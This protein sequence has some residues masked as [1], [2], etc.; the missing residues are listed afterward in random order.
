MPLPLSLARFASRDH[1]LTFVTDDGT[2]PTTPTAISAMPA[3]CTQVAGTESSL[4]IALFKYNKIAAYPP[5][6]MACPTRDTHSCVILR[7]QRRSR[8]CHASFRPCYSYL[9]RSRKKSRIDARRNPGLRSRSVQWSCTEDPPGTSRQAGAQNDDRPMTLR[10]LAD[11]SA[12]SQYPRMRVDFPAPRGLPLQCLRRPVCRA[13]Q[14]VQTRSW[15]ES[16]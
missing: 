16:Y 9:S 5:K 7:I 15:S 8:E 14:L 1:C 13:V 12:S 11:G 3:Y 10:S 6:N 2:S 4:A